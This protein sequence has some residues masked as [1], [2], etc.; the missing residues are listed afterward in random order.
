MDYEYRQA[1]ALTEAG[2]A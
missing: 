1:R 2:M